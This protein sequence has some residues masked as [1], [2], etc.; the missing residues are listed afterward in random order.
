MDPEGM[1]DQQFRN[2]GIEIAESYFV[3][4]VLVARAQLIRGMAGAKARWDYVI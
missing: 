2:T 3:Q 1:S 4:K